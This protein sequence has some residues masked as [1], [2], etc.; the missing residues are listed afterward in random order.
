M[1]VS[2]RKRLTRKT[3]VLSPVPIYESLVVVKENNDRKRK[4]NKKKE[5]RKKDEN[6]NRTQ[7]KQ[8]AP[9]VMYN[10]KILPQ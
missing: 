10:A 6:T 7:T 9:H 4:K 1:F 5:E 2:V 3:I 8:N